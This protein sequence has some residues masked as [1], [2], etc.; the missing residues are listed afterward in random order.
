MKKLS[1][2]YLSIGEE[3][4][5]VINNKNFFE[6]TVTNLYENCFAVS[7]STRQ[8]MYKPIEA[9]QKIRFILVSRNEAHTCSSDVLGCKLGDAYE[10][11]LL[12]FPEIENSIERRKYPRVQVVMAAEYCMLPLGIEYKTISEVPAAYYRKMKKTFTVDISGNGIKIITY[13]DGNDSESAVL[14]LFIDE[15][16]RIL[17][18]V[19]RREFD[20]VTKKAKTAFQFKDIDKV[21]WK[22]LDK[23]VNDKLRV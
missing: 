22:I 14:S 17:C 5:F 8:D 2:D 1:K 10:I 21:K 3:I 12:S 13:E 4:H 6:G 18:S 9:K 19:I 16:I 23:F 15:E 7:I 11:V 20:E